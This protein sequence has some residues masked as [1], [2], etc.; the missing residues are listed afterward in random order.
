MD[1]MI[2]LDQ[3]TGEEKTICDVVQETYLQLQDPEIFTISEQQKEACQAHFDICPECQ[4]FIKYLVA[5]QIKAGIASWNPGL[6]EDLE[7]KQKRA[8]LTL[9]NCDK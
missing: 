3:E 5:Q 1:E 7:K 4:G 9:I 8:H 6:K 2:F